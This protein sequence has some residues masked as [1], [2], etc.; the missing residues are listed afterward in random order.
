MAIRAGPE[1][2][3]HRQSRC[4]GAGAGLSESVQNV[5]YVRRF[6]TGA[7]DVVDQDV[8]NAG[9]AH[10]GG[11][12]FEPAAHGVGAG[13]TAGRDGDAPAGREAVEVVGME[14]DD[15]MVD[16][17]NGLE[18]GDGPVDDAAPGEGLPLLWHLSSGAAAT[19]RGNDDGGVRH[20]I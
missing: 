15:D 9:F 17:G 13:R 16:L 20:A 19:A 2:V 1:G 8:Q 4:N 7:G 18:S 12:M 14:H 6:C 10:I 11:Q 5:R 3:G